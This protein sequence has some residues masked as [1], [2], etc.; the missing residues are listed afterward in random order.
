MQLRPGAD[1]RH[2]HRAL[3]SPGVEQ[4]SP[5]RFVRPAVGAGIAQPQHLAIGQPDQP[6]ALHLQKQRIDRTVQPDHRLAVEG[7]PHR[8]VGLDLRPAP[9]WRDLLTAVLPHRP[10][11]RD[12][13]AAWAARHQIVRQSPHRHDI[14]PAGLKRP[15]QHRFVIA[16]DQPVLHASAGG[17]DLPRGE[18]RFKKRALRCAVAGRNRRGTGA[19]RRELGRQSCAAIAAKRLP[20][21]LKIVHLPAGQIAPLCSTQRHPCS[22]KRRRRSRRGGRPGRHR[23]GR[24]PGRWLLLRRRGA[25]GQNEDQHGSDSVP[26]AGR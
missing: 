17:H 6:R 25:S 15:V 18:L 9:V 1:D 20:D 26:E 3:D 2:G 7:V 10:A 22:C 24:R 19:D 8:R 11:A 4:P 21:A 14:R 16:G 12:T 23:N 5:D 13:I